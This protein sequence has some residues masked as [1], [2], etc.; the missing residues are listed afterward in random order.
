[1]S[2]NLNNPRMGS[3]WYRE[4]IP[5]PWMAVRCFSSAMGGERKIHDV[6]ASEGDGQEDAKEG[7]AAKRFHASARRALALEISSRSLA[8]TDSSVTGLADL[9]RS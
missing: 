7:A 9:A 4:K 5:D 6:L 3:N 1:M 2:I 8:D